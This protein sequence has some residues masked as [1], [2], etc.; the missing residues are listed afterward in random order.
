MKSVSIGIYTL[1]F[2]NG[3]LVELYQNGFRTGL[4]GSLWEIACNNALIEN[5]STDVTVVQNGNSAYLIWNCDCFSVQ[6]RAACKY[7]LLYLSADVSGD[8]PID[9]FTFPLFENICDFG[10][11]EE[12]Y[13]VVPYQSGFVVKNPIKNLVNAPNPQTFWAG[14]G[15]GTG[16]YEN[17]YPASPDAEEYYV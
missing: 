1:E 4:C 16:W 9:S 6:V 15:D 14:R 11:P 3:R 17:D 8:K 2:D 13:M 7:N 12:S 10:T 5:K